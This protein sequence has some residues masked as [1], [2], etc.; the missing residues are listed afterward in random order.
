[1]VGENE[2]LKPKKRDL[3]DVEYLA[4]QAQIF[5]IF[6][7][8]KDVSQRKTDILECTAKKFRLRRSKTLHLYEGKV[9]NA[10]WNT[11]RNVSNPTRTYAPTL[12]VGEEDGLKLKKRDLKGEVQFFS[13]NFFLDTKKK[14]SSTISISELKRSLVIILDV[15]ES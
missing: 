2:G 5:S 4:P 7:A 10:R 11:M 15:S 8:E 6:H 9:S 14:I 13:D 12:Q 3:R 1:M